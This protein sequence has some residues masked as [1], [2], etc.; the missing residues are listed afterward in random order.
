M[1]G[2]IVLA[3][4]VF[5][6][7]V[8]L[9]CGVLVLGFRWAFAGAAETLAA[10]IDRHGE[11]TR[12]AGERAGQP[13]EAALTELAGRV[14]KHSLAVAEAGRTIATPRVTLLGPVPIVDH[15]PIRIQGTRGDDRSLPV[16]VQLQG[17]SK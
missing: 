13:I 12:S 9:G 16:D 1:R 11:L 14:D 6:L 15:E 4:A 10:S 2:N 5:G 7:A 8:V 3:A 17:K